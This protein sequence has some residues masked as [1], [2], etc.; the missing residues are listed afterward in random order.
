MV[1]HPLA[2]SLL[3]P[4][5]LPSSSKLSIT[6]FYLRLGIEHTPNYILSLNLLHGIVINGPKLPTMAGHCPRLPTQTLRLRCQSPQ[7]TTAMEQVQMLLLAQ[8]KVISA[9]QQQLMT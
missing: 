1:T 2:T 8:I 9:L 4:T 6:R 5:L 7:V 3:L